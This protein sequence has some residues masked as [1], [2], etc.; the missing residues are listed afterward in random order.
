MH[1]MIMFCFEII[2]KHSILKLCLHNIQIFALRID[3]KLYTIKCI[4]KKFG[5]FIDPTFPTVFEKNPKSLELVAISVCFA[6]STTHNLI[7]NPAKFSLKLNVV[8]LKKQEVACW[9]TLIGQVRYAVWAV[10]QLAEIPTTHTHITTTNS[11]RSA[12]LRTPTHPDTYTRHWRAILTRNELKFFLCLFLS[13]A[14]SPWRC[15]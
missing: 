9:Q 5:T 10:F 14:P 4:E 15:V 7:V 2:Y 3:G 6:Q 12:H 1:K 13:A 11:P 8:Q